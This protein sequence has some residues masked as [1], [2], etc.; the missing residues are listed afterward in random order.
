MKKKYWIAI[1]K[2]VCKKSVLEFVI[3]LTAQYVL[4]FNNIL[5][6]VVPMIGKLYILK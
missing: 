5:F 3:L 6:C 4:I 2:K 1:L